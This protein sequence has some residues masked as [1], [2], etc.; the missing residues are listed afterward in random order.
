MR[1]VPVEGR[2]G[3][4]I[5]RVFDPIQFCPLLQ[6]RLQTVEIDLTDDTGSI[7]I[8]QRGRMVVILHCRKDMEN[9]EEK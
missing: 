3:E 4:M 5:T 8:F 6:K 1:I 9:T 2:Y 7:V